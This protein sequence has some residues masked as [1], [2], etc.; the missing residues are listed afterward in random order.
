MSSTNGPPAVKRSG[1]RII[2]NP[3][4]RE[5]RPAAR[6]GSE[7]GAASETSDARRP[8]NDGAPSQKRGRGRPKKSD[9]EQ[10][11]PKNF[12]D[13]MMKAA[14][15]QVKKKKRK[16]TSEDG[17]AESGNKK[18]TGDMTREPGNTSNDDDELNA[19]G[20][21][22]SKPSWNPKTL[23]YILEVRERMIDSVGFD[24]RGSH[25]MYGEWPDFAS[26]VVVTFPDP[27]WRMA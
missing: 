9:K 27:L 22:R 4:Y 5:T 13:K 7:N 26:G 1:G 12:F 24:Q 3:Y 2:N 16:V 8:S 15:K 25:E 21:S 18:T 17:N 14:T 19:L 10:P 23:D 20:G 6:N 11:P